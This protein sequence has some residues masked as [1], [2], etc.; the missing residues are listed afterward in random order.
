MQLEAWLDRRELAHLQQS[1]SWLPGRS[2]AG[3]VSAIMIETSL[4]ALG[5][6]TG[7]RNSILALEER[8]DRSPDTVEAEEIL[9]ARSD[10]ITLGAVVSDQ[11]P[12]LQ[13][14]SSTDKPFFH[15]KDA[16]E[17]MNCALVNLHA[18]DG[19]LDWLDG[20]IGALRAG[21]EMHAQDQT[22]RRL[23]MLTILSA[24]FNPAT[25][26]AGIWGMNFARMPELQY[27]LGYPIA[28]GLMLVIGVLMFLF[29]RRGGWFD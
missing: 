25:L 5:H 6:T 4:Q 16:Q 21:F 1:E 3:L 7:L 9:N 17:Y 27:P 13:A 29:F 26:L 8:M 14:L 15:L 19:S 20:R 11:L 28:L 2:T 23:N 12:A 10:L 24:I 22:N 18:V